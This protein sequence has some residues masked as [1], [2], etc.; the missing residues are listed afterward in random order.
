[1]P[2][3]PP[4]VD[5]AGSPRR[6]LVVDDHPMFRLGLVRLL[7]REPGLLLCAE[8]SH[9]RDAL[10]AARVH[11]PDL[12]LVD[13]SMPGISGLEL[14]KA[15]L[16]EH[17]GLR[18]LVLSMHDESL[19]ALRAVRAGALGFV[20]KDAPYETLRIAIHQVAEGR[21]Y[22]SPALADRLLFH[23]IHHLQIESD[24]ELDSLSTREREVLELYGRGLATHEIC[25]HFQIGTKT[26]ET[27][28]TRLKA[29]LGLANLRD[30]IRFARDW[31]RQQSAPREIDH[32]EPPDDSLNAA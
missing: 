29:K 19:Y 11:R 20:S 5:S 32:R 21:L 30:L 28:R 22:L 24:P 6:V 26:V 12:A 25:E 2:A 15:L 23:A 4:S 3:L 14:I 31:V 18:M 8:A 27:Y 17:P 16:A 10:E 9:F 7:E 1:M 13:V